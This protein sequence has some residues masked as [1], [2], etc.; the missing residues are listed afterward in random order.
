[1]RSFQRLGWS[2]CVALALATP[3]AGWAQTTAAPSRVSGPQDR[4]M[5][6]GVVRK[7][8]LNAGTITL[9]HG[10]IQNLAMPGMTMVFT[11]Q[12]KALLAPLKVGDKIRFHAIKDNNLYMVTKIEAV[13]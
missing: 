7:L 6:E 3:W 11:A 10:D 1:M 8:D 5:A 2:A 4:S 9:Q 13:K 12:D